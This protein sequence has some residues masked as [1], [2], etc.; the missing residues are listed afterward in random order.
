M[1]TSQKKAVEWRERSMIL[2]LESMVLA[3]TMVSVI[4]EDFH[5]PARESM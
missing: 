4:G 5:L 2:S 1:A 3:R